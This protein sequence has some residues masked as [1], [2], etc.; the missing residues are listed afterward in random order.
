MRSFTSFSFLFFLLV[1]FIETT[2]QVEV[3]PEKG[4]WHVTTN[5]Y[6]GKLL[7]LDSTAFIT[8]HRYRLGI[9][10]SYGSFHFSKKG[11]KTYVPAYTDYGEY[12]HN[13]LFNTQ[14]TREKDTLSVLGG[15][16]KIRSE[17][18]V[19][20][21]FA[22]N[23]TTVSGLTLTLLTDDSSFWGLGE[24][25]SHLNFAGK[26]PFIFTEEQGLGR[27]DKPLSNATRLFK[28]AGNEFTSYA[29]MPLFITNRNRAVVIENSPYTQFDFTVPGRISIT[30]HGH[31]MK[32]RIYYADSLPELLRHLTAYTG[33]MP[34]LPD[35]AFGTILGIQGGREKVWR[36][37][38][39]AKAAGN[40]V[41]GVWF[42]DWVGR[43]KTRLGSQ[44]WWN[45]YPDTASYPQLPSFISQLNAEGVKALG[46][47]NPFVANYGPLCDTAR[48]R[49]YLVKNKKGNC[50]LL[51]TGGFPAYLVDLTN[52]RAYQWL[53]HMVK[54][55]LIG[56][57]FSGWMADFGEW[58]PADAVLHNGASGL[59]YHNQYTV[60]WA[61]LNREAIAEAGKEGTC[62]FFNRSGALGSARYSTL[63]WAGDQTVD[64]GRHD[65]LPSAL[66]AMLSSGLSGITLNHSDAGGYTTVD[67]AFVR[68]K[69][70]AD[71]LKRWLELSAFTP[72]FRTHEGVKPLSNLQ[73][74]DNDSIRSFYARM[75]RLHYA[76]LP[77]L[78]QLNREA[79]QK[80]MPVVRPLL[81]HFAD[82]T[83]THSLQDQFLL[84]DALLVAPVITP[85]TLSRR[86]YLPEGEWQ[87]VWTGKTYRGPAHETI[88]A[89]YGQPPVFIRQ[90]MPSTQQ[91]QVVFKQF[92]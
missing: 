56:T 92:K 43:R 26:S 60:D 75:G 23:D 49:G 72:V 38:Q 15:F 5:G 28:V 10:A 66:C 73:V 4:L 11:L 58:L 39:A 22:A 78:Q 21:Q 16:G 51:K 68:V 45:W 19:S 40:P 53:K 35:W 88:P 9:T 27:G 31:L 82:D 81:L 52:P 91:L 83:A 42:Q 29:P 50:Y 41:T 44:L 36:E 55:Q 30:T 8:A 77:Y 62:F 34:Q 14:L 13:W 87:H 57:G 37:V 71:V 1:L 12:E 74:Y 32:G 2:A 65:G 47:I 25:Y 79:A 69:R 7:T 89:P 63:F 18:Y 85:N 80:G 64:F 70:N 20:F 86:V 24:Q 84:G 61:R 59:A 76:L 48:A 54:T 67:N 17:H 90:Q 6:A 33:R 3:E 46:Y